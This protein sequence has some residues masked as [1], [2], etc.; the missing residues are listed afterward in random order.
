M[1]KSTGYAFVEQ[2]QNPL[3]AIRFFREQAESVNSNNESEV[4]YGDCMREWNKDILFLKECL[5]KQEVSPWAFDKL[6]EM[7]TYVQYNPDWN[8][9]STK[10]R[11]LKDTA[12]LE[13]HL[14]LAE[15]SGR[16]A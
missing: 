10:E 1:E 6:N 8:V 5:Q 9:K 3:E 2:P 7:Q 12:L 16:S 4:D 15:N 13:E 11:L 14:K